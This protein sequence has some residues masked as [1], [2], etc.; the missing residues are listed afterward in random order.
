MTNTPAHVP[1]APKCAGCGQSKNYFVHTIPDGH[2]FVS[3]ENLPTL[4][5][6]VKGDPSVFHDVIRTC[7]EMNRIKE[8]HDTC[9]D[10]AAKGALGEQVGGDHYRVM[11]I[12]PVE[13]IHANGLGFFEGVV[14]KY[15]SRWRRKNG[16]EDLR[17]AIHFLQLLIELETKKPN[18]KPESEKPYPNDLIP[19]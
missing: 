3:G 5:E 17:K 11:G 4:T 7:D 15:V 1:Q 8:D 16:L 10:R 12:Q 19:G 6:L 14:V 2:Q 13:Y 9:A 18:S